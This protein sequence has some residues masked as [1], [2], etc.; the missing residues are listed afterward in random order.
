MS[1]P[2]P[3]KVVRTWYDLRKEVRGLRDFY[4]QALEAAEDLVVAADMGDEVLL[5]AVLDRHGQLKTHE[6]FKVSPDL[7]VKVQNVN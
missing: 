6:A 4:R 1:P 2:H 5:S 7:F 3:L